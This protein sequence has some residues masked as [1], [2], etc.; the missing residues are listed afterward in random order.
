MG[1]CQVLITTQDSAKFPQNAP[2]T[3]HESLS[4]G[5]RLD[6]AEELLRKVS[7]VS[8]QVKNVAELLDFQPLAL[9][10][11]A[12]YVKTVKTSGSCNYDWKAYLH[13]ISTYSQQ[14]EIETVLANES[15]AY[16][17]TTM[18]AVEMAIKK[19]VD[20]DE[21]LLQTFSFLALCAHGDLP[22]ET[23]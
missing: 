2:H 3:Y 16:G 19:A 8:E 13:D 18:A 11:A 7:Q 9:A 1:P 12:Y 21:V 14:K 15:P 22:L 10:A 4:K 17:K 5:M 20:T 23:V 6:E